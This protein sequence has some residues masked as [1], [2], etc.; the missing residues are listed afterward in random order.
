MRTHIGLCIITNSIGTPNAFNYIYF[1][2]IISHI[3]P[4]LSKVIPLQNTI[5]QDRNRHETSLN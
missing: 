2:L 1:V 5:L 3:K 4:K